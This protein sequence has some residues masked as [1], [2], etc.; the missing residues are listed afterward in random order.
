MSEQHGHPLL[1]ILA[2]AALAPLV[3]E[4]PRRLRLP[5]AVIEVA[6]GIV[7][8]PYALDL[9]RPTEMI[10]SLAEMGL[11][12]LFFHAGL[13]IDFGAIRGRPLALAVRGWIVSLVLAVTAAQALYWGGFVDETRYVSVA[14]TTTAVGMLL[15]ILRDSD[16]LGTLFGR[17]V[18]A[19]GSLGEFGPVVL[20][21]LLLSGSG[22]VG[23]RSLLMVTLVIVAVTVV[24]SRCARI[25]HGWSRC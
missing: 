15:P 5:G 3:G 13:E 20:L 16:E 23:G 12:A 14:L 17:H 10:V 18:L 25:R 1:V 8:G 24:L 6:L 21:S 11:A 2:V 4:L 9:V 7:V 22:S 19:A